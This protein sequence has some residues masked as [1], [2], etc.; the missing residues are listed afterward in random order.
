MIT[1]GEPILR[2][3]AFPSPQ[4]STQIPLLRGSWRLFHHDRHGGSSVGLREAHGFWHEAVGGGRGGGGILGAI[5]TDPIR[6]RARCL[7][8]DARSHSWNSSGH[9]PSTT[10]CANTLWT[11]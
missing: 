5:R 1:P 10:P 2:R 3:D 4:H 11:T 7:H 9:S 8:C 6:D